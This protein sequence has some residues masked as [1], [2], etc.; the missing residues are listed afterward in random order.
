MQG[1][2]QGQSKGHYFL[3]LVFLVGLLGVFANPARAAD[4]SVTRANQGS[5]VVNVRG[6]IG[7]A[8]AV[9]F[10]RATA[11]LSHAKVVFH[12]PGGHAA[13]G[14]LIGRT[15][16]S[17]GFTTDVA[18]SGRCASACALAWLGGAQRQMSGGR[19]GF[20]AAYGMQGG[21]AVRDAGANAR[22]AGYLRQI[23]VPARAIAHIVQVSPQGMYWLT[24][25][26]ARQAGITLSSR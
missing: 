21:R 4:I 12:S 7:L 20:H 17:K 13:A 2:V 6:V 19:V 8:D 5:A 26:T 1:Q 18:P 10:K 14:I 9:R 11:G 3:S 23:G 15:I 16:R 24:P 22:V 25:S